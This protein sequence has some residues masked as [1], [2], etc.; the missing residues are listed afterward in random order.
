MKKMTLFFKKLS[1]GLLATSSLLLLLACS[2]PVTVDNGM[3]K[4]NLSTILVPADISFTLQ[5]PAANPIIAPERDFYILGQII[6]DIPDDAVLTVQLIRNSD[7]MLMREV[8]TDIKANKD[9][10]YWDYPLITLYGTDDPLMVKDSLMPDLIYDPNNVGTFQEQWRKCYYDDYNYTATFNGGRYT[11]DVYPYDQWGHLYEPILEGEYTV[12]ISAETSGGDLLGTSSFPLTI[13]YNPEKVMSRFS[14]P[15]HYSNIAAF[16][17]QHDYTLYTDPFAGLFDTVQFLVNYPPGMEIWINRKWRIGDLIEYET[18]RVHFLI[19]DVAT[20]STTW[21]VELGVIQA[22]RSVEDPARLVNYYYDIGDIA[23]GGRAGNFVPFPPD[24]RLQMVRVDYPLGPT[25]EN[26]I[27]YSDLASVKSDFDLS[28]GVPVTTDSIISFFGVVKPIQV[29]MSDLDWNEITSEYIIRN[30]PSIVEYHIQPQG[31]QDYYIERNIGLQ[32]E[33]SSTNIVESLLEFKNN[34][35]IDPIWANSF[36][37]IS[38][39]AYDSHGRLIG[40]TY[41]EF[42]LIVGP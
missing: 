8:F 16:A 42:R 28:D 18:G 40:E 23:V 15:D 21:A 34:F 25:T 35:Y 4:S 10:I 6:G 26:Y 17:L 41:E 31:S 19:Y 5:M 27:V 20:N 39:V 24:D 33:F 3:A 22:T 36:V 38:L 30:R 11:Y 32:R 29:D 2:S 1:L 14:P 13:G 7:S 12:V 9:G 37:D